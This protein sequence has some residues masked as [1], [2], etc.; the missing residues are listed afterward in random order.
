MD[1]RLQEGRVL[2]KERYEA[3]CRA[4]PTK[5]KWS[6]VQHQFLARWTSF[7]KKR[8]ENI[9]KLDLETRPTFR[10]P[11]KEALVWEEVAEEFFESQEKCIERL[12]ARDAEAEAEMK[13]RQEKVAD[14]VFKS[15]SHWVFKNPLPDF[16][17]RQS[18]FAKKRDMSFEERLATMRG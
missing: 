4:P 14:A 16:Y 17:T 2:A 18:D 9:E 6:Q 13:K 15:K 5:K 7:N 3:S 8:E 11:G 1:R 10:Q 12:K